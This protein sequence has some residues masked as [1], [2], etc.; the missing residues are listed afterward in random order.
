MICDFNQKIGSI[1]IPQKKKLKNQLRL[2][3][4][5]EKERRIAI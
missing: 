5:Y 1:F 4:S 3:F 2:R